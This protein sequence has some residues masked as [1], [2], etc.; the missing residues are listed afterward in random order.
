MVKVYI[1]GENEREMGERREVVCGER[2][3]RCVRGW[4][5]MN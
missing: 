4:G 5:T 2:D 3:K 1:F